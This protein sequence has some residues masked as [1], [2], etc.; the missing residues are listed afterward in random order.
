[1]VVIFRAVRTLSV[2]RS[3]HPRGAALN[4]RGSASTRSAS[5]FASASGI[6]GMYLRAQATMWSRTSPPKP[7]M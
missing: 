4:L 5:A 3:R 2:R 6:A 1:M 7:T